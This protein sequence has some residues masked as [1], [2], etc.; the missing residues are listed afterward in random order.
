MT[1][2]PE[3]KAWPFNVAVP[4]EKVGVTVE[5]LLEPLTTPDLTKLI[6]NVMVWV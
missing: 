2:V 6:E 1:G 4:P 5:G 3:V